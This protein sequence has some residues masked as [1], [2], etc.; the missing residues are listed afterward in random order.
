MKSNV[1]NL[2]QGLRRPG[3]QFDMTVK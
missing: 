3:I 2:E 1:K